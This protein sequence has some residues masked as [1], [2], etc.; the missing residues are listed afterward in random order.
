VLIY[1][2]K[3][4]ISKL[5][6]AG[7][8]ILFSEAGN[9]GYLY[10]NQSKASKMKNWYAIY[11]KPRSEKKVTERLSGSGIEAY[12]PL[13]KTL[14]QWSDRKKKVQ[15]PMFPGYVFV[16]I[17]EIER[18]LVLQD[19]G[20]LNFVFWLGKPAII[21]D[22]EI[23]AIREIA[24]RGEE[25]NISSEAFEVGRLVKIPEGPFKGMTGTVDKLDKRKVIVL[26]EQLGCMVSFRYKTE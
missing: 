7:M 21:R 10:P 5:R 8:N 11:T 17:S 20:V 14:R 4:H 3:H 19:Y 22:N 12:C 26:V 18:I 13:M 1:L 24:D 16:Y 23:N 9:K 15:L 25:I 2:K 6:P